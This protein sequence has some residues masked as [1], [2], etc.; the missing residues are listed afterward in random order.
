M[1]IPFYS[2][3]AQNQ[4]IKNQVLAAMEEV[5][6]SQWYVL[7]K[8]VQDFEEAYARFSQTNYCIGVANGLDALR[9]AL[10]TLGIGPGDEVIVPSNTYIATWLAVSHTGARPVPVE[11]N[12]LTYNLEPANIE[13][14]ITS[15]TKA[16]IPV[17]LYGQACEMDAIMDIA[18]QHHLF[19][20][21]DNAQAQGATFNGKKTGSFGH[22]NATSFYPAK[23]LGALG[24]AGA[25]TTSNAA[26]DEK[27]RMLRNYG[28]REKYY[29]EI[30]GLNSRLD[31]MQAAILQVKLPYLESWNAARVQ[32]AEFYYNSLKE[33]EEIVLPRLAVSATH[34]YHQFVI[35][36]QF[37]DELQKYLQKN[38]VVTL[39]H[40]PVPPH[41]QEAYNH[42]GYKKGDFPVAEEL[43]QTCLSLP[44]YP[45]L[46]EQ[47][48]IYIANLIKDF[49]QKKAE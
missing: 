19:V 47:E 39:I 9:I 37:R 15:R 30:I 25:L 49:L 41:L 23:N 13:A 35:R 48:V 5:F 32:T 10:L 34:V 46:Q 24:D 26:L 36:T 12:P 14:A 29:N 8:S 1:Q 31:E 16:I 44:V 40:Y 27:A 21:E 18:R 20:V 43:A 45:G 33:A 7:G 42:L 11:P 4:Q 17:H 3:E 28:S 22:I 38:G 6:D 2:F